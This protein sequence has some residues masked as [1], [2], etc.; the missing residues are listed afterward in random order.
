MNIVVKPN[1][2]LD[3]E[4]QK[5]AGYVLPKRCKAVKVSRQ[6]KCHVQESWLTGSMANKQINDNPSSH[7]HDLTRKKMY[8]TWIS[9]GPPITKI[10]FG[11]SESHILSDLGLS[12]TGK[13]SRLQFQLEVDIYIYLIKLNYVILN[14]IL[15]YIIILYYILDYIMILY[16]II[17]YYII[18]YI[19]LYHT[20]L[21]YKKKKT[22]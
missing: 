12:F 21:D 1:P 20:I 3:I 6:S 2:N 9:Y 14:Y 7:R 17:L 22:L 4:L 11:N 10:K 13:Y 16:Y 5:I 15:H 8:H 18:V 19:T